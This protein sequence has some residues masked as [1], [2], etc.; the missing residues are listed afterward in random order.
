L[1]SKQHD[2]V[3]SPSL[4]RWYSAVAPVRRQDGNCDFQIANEEN[5][6]CCLLTVLALLGPRTALA[7][8]WLVDQSWFNRIYDTFIWPFLGFLF[9]PF[10]TLMYTLV[11]TPSV[12]VTGWNW[13][14]VILAV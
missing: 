10:T 9:L 14:W 13:I 3:R 2:V 7:L 12:G 8:W 1:Y 11:A 6:M 5:Y 4:A